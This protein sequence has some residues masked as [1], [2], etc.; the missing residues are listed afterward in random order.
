MA[1]LAAW[2][3]LNKVNNRN[4]ARFSDAV[5]VVCPNVTIR[6][7]LGELNPDSGVASLYRTRD[8]VPEHLMADLTQGHV[9]V[10]NWHVFEPQTTT[11]AGTGARVIRAGVRVETREK[12]VIG[13][14]TTTARGTRY[15]TEEELQRQI[16]AGMLEII[17]DGSRQATAVLRSV[18]VRRWD[19]VE[20]DAAVVNRVLG[21]DLG[22]KQNVLVFNDEAHHAYRIQ[23]ERPDEW[24]EMDER[25]ARRLAR[26]S[27]K[28]RRSGWMAWI[29]STS[30]GESISALTCRRRLI[31]SGEWGKRRIE[32]FRG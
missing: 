9:L 4:D 7:R 23:N 6:S 32:P 13:S 25:R 28:R 14:K 10:T 18:Q 22:G 3:I 8:I 19:Y 5:L 11:A 26:T 27:A 21:R 17:G 12:I 31:F 30:I 24:D 2:S 15:M 20:S 29:A 1:M 16:G